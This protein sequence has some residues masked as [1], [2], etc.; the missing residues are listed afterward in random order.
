LKAEETGI[1]VYR[2]KEKREKGRKDKERDPEFER[3]LEK[4]EKRI[5]GEDAE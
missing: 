3:E 5:E 1:G 2:N 4:G